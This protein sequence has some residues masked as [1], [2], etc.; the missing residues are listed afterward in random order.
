MSWRATDRA[1][2]EVAAELRVGTRRLVG[3]LKN[4]SHESISPALARQKE[5]PM[6][7]A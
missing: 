5:A 4:T 6:A 3:D 1:L 7:R 2:R